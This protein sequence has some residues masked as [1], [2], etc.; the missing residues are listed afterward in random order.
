MSDDFFDELNAEIAKHI[1]KTQIRKNAAAA[2]KIAMN[3]AVEEVKRLAA[4]REYRE[5]QAIIDADIWRPVS[6][7]AFFTEQRCD[8][9]GSHHHVFLQYMEQQVLRTK[10]SDKRW[11]RVS[12]PEPHLTKEVL[13]QV[14]R[15]H[16]CPDCCGDHGFDLESASRFD[17]P[18]PLAVS[19]TYDQGDINAPTE[20]SG[21]L[22]PHERLS[23]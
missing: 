8:G 12:H 18:F 13:I 21:T 22:P 19:T 2:K 23:A 3:R 10:P 7:V 1:A 5:L 16:V 14:H 9:C 15:T 4:L 11:V 20:E 17:M 6:L